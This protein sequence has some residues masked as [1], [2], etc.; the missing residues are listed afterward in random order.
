MNHGRSGQFWRGKEVLITGGS[1]GIGKQPVAW[2]RPRVRLSPRMNISQGTALS[3][4]R[5]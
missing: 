4:R 2:P 5:A 3:W 1:S